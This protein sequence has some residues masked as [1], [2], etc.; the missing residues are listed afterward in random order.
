MA[1]AWETPFKQQVRGAAADDDEE[2][3]SQTER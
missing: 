1:N 3:N 2:E